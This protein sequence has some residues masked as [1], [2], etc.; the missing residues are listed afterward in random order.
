MRAEI[1][2]AVQNPIYIFFFINNKKARVTLNFAN[3]QHNNQT[4]L[5]SFYSLSIIFSAKPSKFNTTY[6]KMNT[7]SA[8]F[9]ILK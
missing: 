2:D 7:V 1:Q 9:I 8:A 5:K 3:M 6:I 4:N